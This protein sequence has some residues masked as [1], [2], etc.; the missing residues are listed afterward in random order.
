[1]KWQVNTGAG[2]VDLSNGGV[3]SGV[4]TATLTITGAAADMNGDKYRA[5][6][7][8]GAAPDATS[9]AATL[10]VNPALG[11]TPAMLPTGVAQILLPPDN[12]RSRRHHAVHGLLGE[13]F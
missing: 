9:T 8:N 4:T 6:F 3:Y 5:V 7:S 13:R 2:F 11:I 1:M 12:R 10:T